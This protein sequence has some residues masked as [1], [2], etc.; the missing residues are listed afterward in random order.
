MKNKITALLNV[1]ILSI[2]VMIIV[3]AYYEKGDFWDKFVPG[4]PSIFLVH[5]IIVW[6]GAFDKALIIPE[7]YLSAMLISMLFMVPIYL[8][9]TKI[10]KTIYA[11]LILIGVVALIA[12]ISG[13][14]TKW[15]F[16][17]NL[18]YDIRA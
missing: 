17:E 1:H 16:N 12:I 11:T 18:L 9:F 13:L 15:A 4:I 10:V 2:V 7:W 14:A 3:L 8:L 6:T 5:M